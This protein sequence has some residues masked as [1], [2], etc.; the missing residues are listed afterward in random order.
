[1]KPIK[2]QISRDVSLRLSNK[3]LQGR[4]RWK[5]PIMI[6]CFHYWIFSL[7]PTQNSFL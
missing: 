3:P 1:L 5:P 2:T 4:K 7:A 6:K